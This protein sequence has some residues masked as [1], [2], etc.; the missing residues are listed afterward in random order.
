MMKIKKL[1]QSYFAK[2]KPL[3][4]AGDAFFV[5]FLVL[6]LIPVT[7]IEVVSMIKR[8]AL[9]SPSVEIVKPLGELKQDDYA[10][11]LYDHQ[12]K[13]VRLQDYKGKVIFVNFWATWCPPCVAE[14]P[15]IQKLY[16]KFKD[17]DGVAFM[18][19]TNEKPE[20]V[21]EF[22]KKK[23]YD[24]PVYFP[25]YRA[26]DIFSAEVLP[27]TFIFKHNGELMIMEAGAADWD[28][29]KVH[30]LILSLKE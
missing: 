22:M 17:D 18:M 11:P 4:I 5:I 29:E 27:T 19:V 14:M 23:G 26:P 12:K 10:W 9:F 24:F 2:K 6:L 21:N 20:K 1:I 25:V 28:S 16:D 13:A 7:R 15:S 3:A 8:I 30:E